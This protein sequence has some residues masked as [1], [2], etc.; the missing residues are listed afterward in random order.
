M[1]ANG[2][3]WSAKR[4]PLYLKEMIMY[5]VRPDNLGHDVHLTVFSNKLFLWQEGSK[6]VVLLMAVCCRRCHVFIS[7]KKTILSAVVVI[8]FLWGMFGPDILLFA[9]VT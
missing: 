2:S 7:Y 6:K 3:R 4:S 8:F 5:R 9:K 1:E